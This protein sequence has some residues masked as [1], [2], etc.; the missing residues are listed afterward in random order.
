MPHYFSFFLLFHTHT[1]I[2][3]LFSIVFLSPIYSQSLCLFLPLSLLWPVICFPAI[4]GL[5]LMGILSFL[6]LGQNQWLTS[7]GFWLPV[8]WILA[9]CILKGLCS[10]HNCRASKTFVTFVLGWIALF[11]IVGKHMD[12]N[13]TCVLAGLLLSQSSESFVLSVPNVNYLSYGWFCFVILASF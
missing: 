1:H 5:W 11:C 6:F 7:G 4:L 8:R 2:Q 12:G 13:E 9:S 10:F 3:F